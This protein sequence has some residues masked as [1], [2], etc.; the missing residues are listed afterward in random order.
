MRKK[1]Q[2]FV[3]SISACLLLFSALIILNKKEISEK[4]KKTPIFKSLYTVGQKNKLEKELN[5]QIENK[6]LK[7]ILQNLS[8]D[9]LEIA[10]SILRD[11]KTVNF[12]NEKDISGYLS[13][14]NYE[15]SLENKKV[16]DNIRNLQVLSPSIKDYFQNRF[17]KENFESSMKKIET[18]PQVLMLRERITKLLPIKEAEVTLNNLSES[19][20]M[21]ISEILSK[22]PITVEYVDK[23]NLKNYSLEQVVEISKT[24]YKIGKIDPK[25]AIEINDSVQEFSIR[26]AALYGDLYVRDEKY[27]KDIKKEIESGRYTFENPYVRYN[28]YGRTP[29]SYGIAFKTDQEVRI[30]VIILGQMGL[31][32]FSYTVNYNGNN[33]IPIVGLYPKIKNTVVI[34]E[35]ES[36]SDQIKR[37]KR[38][39][40]TTDSVD[41]RLPTI[42]VETRVP[43]SIQ[44]GVNLV[45]Y[46]L[47]D[48]SL[49]FAFD[50]M[51]N[52]RYILETGKDMRKVKIAK[53]KY[54]DWELKN[55]EDMFQIDILGKIQ[56]RIGKKDNSEKLKNK[57]VKYLMRNNNLLTV[58]SYKDGSYPHALFSEY[59]LDSKNEIFKAVIYYDK[60]SPSENL[61]LDG[62]RINLYEGD[63]EE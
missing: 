50:S 41:D 55:D 40:L 5:M 39:Y 33:L 29:L 28:P 4:M 47:K 44:P 45:S 57:K 48:E 18:R 15:S 49:P 32:N 11:N 17:V 3:L 21:E 22:S 34:E 46:N 51:G 37:S 56:D 25:L 14:K 26:K 1:E 2:I 35:L 59:G 6:E 23:K 16:I 58:V 12:I 31:P 8:L 38:L 53:G 52:I 10:N 20:L 7:I 60:N 36:G 42:L 19:K 30:K 61:I 54:S 9:K 27:E 13:E 62:E 43:G 63:I 24:L